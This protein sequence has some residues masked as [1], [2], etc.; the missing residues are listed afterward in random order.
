M[1]N[2]PDGLRVD[3]LARIKKVLSRNVRGWLAGTS[4]FHYLFSLHL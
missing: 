3:G 1:E 2:I 4:L